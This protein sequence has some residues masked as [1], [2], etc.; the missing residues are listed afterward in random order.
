MA[1]RELEEASSLQ[2]WSFLEQGVCLQR[3]GAGKNPEVRRK[4]AEQTHHHA[5]ALPTQL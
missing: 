2:H 4:S 1:F 5:G 3:E